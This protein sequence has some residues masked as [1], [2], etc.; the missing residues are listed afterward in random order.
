MSMPREPVVLDREP[1][2]GLVD[3]AS[4][5]LRM[6]MVE[7]ARARGHTEIRFAHNAVLGH[8]SLEGSRASDLA[9][10][11]G[12]TKQSMG[13]VV[14]ELVALG[15]LELR[16]DPDDRRAKL[17][18]YTERGL[19]IALDGREYLIELET[20][21]AEEFGERNYAAARRVLEK[22]IDSWGGGR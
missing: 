22:L 13:E 5:L 17:V 1:F 3:K 4:R 14:R 6:D 8:L 12:I 20:R 18:T 9:E 2:I 16:P 19:Q 7:A 10:R 21:F 15:V 11:A